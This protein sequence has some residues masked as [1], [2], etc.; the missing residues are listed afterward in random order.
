[1]PAHLSYSARGLGVI[2]AGV[3]TARDTMGGPKHVEIS[4]GTVTPAAPERGQ[5]R[6]AVTADDTSAVTWNQ[7]PRSAGRTPTMQ[8]S[9]TGRGGAS[10]VRLLAALVVWDALLAVALLPICAQLEGTEL[11]GGAASPF[12]PLALLLAVASVIGLAIAGG[13]QNRRRR[14]GS[15]LLFALRLLVLGM[16]LSWLAIT[17][18]ATFGW[19]V[20]LSQMAALAVLLPAGW[21]LGRWACDRHPAT[22]VER[23]LLVGSGEVAQR[24]MHLANRHKHHHLAVV[25]RVDGD[26]DARPSGQSEPPLLGDLDE[27]TAIVRNH[28]VDRLIVAFNPGRDSQLVGSLRE[29]IAAG[30]QVDVVPRFF[31]LAGPS[32]RAHSLGDLALMEVPGR[33]LTAPQRA[34]KRLSDIVGA[35]IL[36]A[37]L[38]PVMVAVALTIAVR[39]GRPVLYRQVRVGRAGREFSILKFRTMRP[40]PDIAVNVGGP[41]GDLAREVKEAGTLRLTSTGA[42]LRRTSLDEVPQLFNVLTGAMSLVGPRPLRPFESEALAPWQRCRQDLRP[43]LTGL[44][45]VLGRSDVQWDERM[46]LDYSYVS[47]W[48]FLSDLRILARTLPAV[49]KGDGA[50]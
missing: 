48:S 18:S 26:R 38:S 19:Q 5:S 29:S 27:L 37:V 41:I 43:G 11:N 30:V 28:Q 32:P 4:E 6:V 44:W 12:D 24:V 9:R 39:D 47:H 17:V 8:S 10:R 15:R 49:L 2:R 25:G 20:D 45:Q 16:V 31:D 34:L 3:L 23:V 22:G 40:E 7:P 50:V 42:F 1:M 33:G 21:L 13:Y 14:E 36:I 35:A 46:Q